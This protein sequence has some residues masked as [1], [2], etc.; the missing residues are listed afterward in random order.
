MGDH[1]EKE[2]FISQQPGWDTCEVA[3]RSVPHLGPVGVCQHGHFFYGPD[4]FRQVK[5]VT[6]D[7]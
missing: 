5:R 4:G 1:A 3:V 7:A 2:R 6:G